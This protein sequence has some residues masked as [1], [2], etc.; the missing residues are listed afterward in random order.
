[1]AN[2]L[3]ASDKGLQLVNDAREKQGWN[4]ADR[5]LLETAKISRATLNRFYAQQPIKHDN[6]VAICKAVG[7]E[8]WQRVAATVLSAEKPQVVAEIPP[9]SLVQLDRELRA[10]FKALRYEVESDFLV[11][12]EEYFEW[13]IRVPVRSRF[14]RVLIHGIT[15]EAGM[16]DLARVEAV[17]R[18]RNLAE[19][20]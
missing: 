4:R 7:I 20:R 6:F 2:S 12:T 17:V 9:N 10:W 18:E 16:Q 11:E 3:T 5:R 1:M 13:I 8:K 14:D 19:Q 15:G